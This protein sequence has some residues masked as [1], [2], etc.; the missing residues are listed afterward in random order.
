[1]VCFAVV[2]VLFWALGSRTRAEIV[3]VGPVEPEPVE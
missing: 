3:A 2:G 1:V